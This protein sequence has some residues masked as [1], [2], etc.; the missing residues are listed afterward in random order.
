MGCP[1]NRY[2]LRQAGIPGPGSRES[3]PRPALRIAIATHERAYRARQPRVDPKAGSLPQI[4]HI[5]RKVS[6]R[7]HPWAEC[8][9]ERSRIPMDEHFPA[10]P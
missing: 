1:A 6:L 5:S 9:R 10:T 3:I 4:F 2:R 8:R 7:L